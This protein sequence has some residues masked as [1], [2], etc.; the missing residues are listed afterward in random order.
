MYCSFAMT[1]TITND[2]IYPDKKN[3]LEPKQP[4]AFKLA[5]RKD[6]SVPFDVTKAGS[7]VEIDVKVV[8]E[9]VNP[10]T[11]YLAFHYVDPR[12]PDEK[13]FGFLDDILS[14]FPSKPRAPEELSDKRRVRKLVGDGLSTRPDGTRVLSSKN[15]GISVPIKLKIF[16]N[17][18]GVEKLVYD[19][20]TEPYLF[21]WGRTFNKIIVSEK[22]AKGN[23]KIIA[24]TIKDSPE[25]IGTKITFGIRRSHQAK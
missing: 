23:Y 11:F 7:K 18:E 4:Y 20:E 25:L 12:N 19:K 1:K 21:S 24:E 14:F 22:M 15:P 3:S 16:T 2:P 10:Y 6:I 8:D 9:V 13:E 5:E 17:E